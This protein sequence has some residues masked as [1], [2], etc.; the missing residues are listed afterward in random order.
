M[1]MTV[2]TLD[3]ISGPR[4]EDSRIHGFATDLFNECELACDLPYSY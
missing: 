2:V 1:E 3:D 4:G